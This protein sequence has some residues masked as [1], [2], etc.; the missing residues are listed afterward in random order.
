VDDLEQHQGNLRRKTHETIK[1]VTDDVG[2]RYTF[3]TA[4]AAN[5][6]LVNEITDFED[7]SSQGRA[8]YQEA[9]EAVVLMLAPIV[10][11]VCH[12][13]WQR[14]GHAKP[15]YQA[16]WPGVDLNAL[17]RDTV[18][19]IVQVNGKKRATISVSSSADNQHIK[20]MALANENVQRFAEDKNIVKIIIVPGRLVNIVVA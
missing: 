2:R 7:S 14:L 8:V 10:P 6:E 1:K 19:I 17:K 15:V 4:I 20:E 9:L 3:N 11:H 13:L 18:E 12:V 16:S 5:M